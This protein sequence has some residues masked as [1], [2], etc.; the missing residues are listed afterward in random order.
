[1]RASIRGK[2][3]TGYIYDV[4]WEAQR[5]ERR[6]AVP[7]PNFPES[8]DNPRGGVRGG[9]GV[10]ATREGIVVANYDTLYRYDDDWKLLDS[11]SHPL[12]VGIH[13]IDWDGRHV[14]LAA[15]GLDAVLKTTLD[16]RVEAAWDPHAEG[17]LDGFELR[18]RPHPLDGS[19]DYRIREA[20]LLNQCH[21]N[22]VARRDGSLVVNCGLLRK[23][24]P[25]LARTLRR[26]RSRL[27]VA[28]RKE[29]RPPSRSLVV[30]VDGNGGAALLLELEEHDFPT[31]NGQLI[32]ESVLTVNDSTNNT[33]RVFDLV[34]RSAQERVGLPVPGTWLRGLEPVGDGRVLVGS[35]PASLFLVDIRRGEIEGKVQLSSDP[36]EAVHGLVIAPPLEERI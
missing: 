34:D 26:V 13:E 14:W 30:R 28:K 17:A 25:L 19:V 33:L 12:F 10:A 24:K 4:D 6:L 23:R 27:G 32:D 35:A 3:R 16:G 22:G 18:S 9:R 29:Q 36:N 2:Q 7:D 31:H 21:L 5:V 11:F 20:P 8:D 1:V 15:T